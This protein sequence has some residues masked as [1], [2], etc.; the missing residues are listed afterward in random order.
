MDLYLFS[1]PSFDDQIASSKSSTD[2]EQIVY[3]VVAGWTYYILVDGYLGATNFDYTLSIDSPEPISA[4]FDTDGDIDGTDFLAWQRGA[5]ISAPSATKGDGDA[6]ND[7]D[8]DSTDLEHWADQFG[9]SQFIL[10]APLPM[11]SRDTRNATTRVESSAKPNRSAMAALTPF[12][13]ALLSL[14]ANGLD[15]APPPG[16]FKDTSAGAGV[17]V[18]PADHN[19]RTE[20]GQD[21]IGNKVFENLLP[22]KD[23]R[24]VHWDPRHLAH[25]QSS[26]N[27]TAAI[28]SALTIFWQT[29]TLR[30]LPANAW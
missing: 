23:R 5:G 3:P 1:D 18:H 21:A 11:V 2:S 17:A 29:E 12:E 9:Q 25:P 22:L 13:S 30:G 4:D 27:K 15:T 14:L 19:M 28:D 6:D 26:H 8:V 20:T 7:T 16:G 10:F 24:Y